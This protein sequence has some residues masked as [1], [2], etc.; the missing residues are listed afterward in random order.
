[1]KKNLPIKHEFIHKKNRV[2]ILSNVVNQIGKL[3]DVDP[4]DLYGSMHHFDHWCDQKGYGEFDP[5]GKE[6]S[7]SNI[8]FLEYKNATNGEQ[9]CPPYICFIDVFIHEHPELFPIEYRDDLRGT[10]ICFDLDY[11]ISNIQN[12]NKYQ[13]K[14]GLLVKCLSKMKE[15]YGNEVYFCEQET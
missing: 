3:L 4:Y 13:D 1:M 10:E 6:R 14:D 5:E 12:N 11:L 8:W 15:I 2:Y 9:K 7:K